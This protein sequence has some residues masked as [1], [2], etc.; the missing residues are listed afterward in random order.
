MHAYSICLSA[1]M[2]ISMFKII[3]V[4]PTLTPEATDVEVEVG[5]PLT[6]SV[7]IIEF[8]LEITDIVWLLNDGTAV[9]HTSDVYTITNSSL[10]APVGTVSLSVESVTSPVV[11]GGIYEVTVTNPAGTDTSTFN[12]SIT[13]ESKGHV[14]CVGISAVPCSYVLLSS[15]A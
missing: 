4:P 7:N 6:L 8:N 1:T 14:H 13:S 2:I 3:I 5:M 11:Y 12:V 10:D 9:R 15:V